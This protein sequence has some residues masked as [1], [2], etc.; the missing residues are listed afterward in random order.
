MV[1]QEAKIIEKRHMDAI[2]CTV[3][4]GVLAGTA[5]KKFAEV[6]AFRTT[7]SSPSPTVESCT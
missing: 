4:L 1:Q 2:L 6:E 7:D 5:M 3:N